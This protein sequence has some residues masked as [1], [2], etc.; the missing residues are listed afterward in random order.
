VVVGHV[1]L[2]RRGG[3]L[4]PGGTAWYTSR[5]LVAMG[6]RPR[7]LT[8]AG[9]DYQRE[10]LSG[11][12]A[13]VRPAA[14]T[15]VFENIHGPDG[16]RTQRVL[17][18]AP[19]LVPADLPAEESWHHADGLLL[20]LVLD[21]LVPRAFVEAV[22]APVTGLV[23]QGLLRRVGA[24]GAVSQPRWDPGPDALRGVGVAFL[25]EDDL[26]GQGPLHE[27]LAAQVP[28]VVLTH[29]ARGCELWASGR[30][31]EVGVFPVSEVD[32]TGA[33]DAFAA[34]FLLALTRGADPVE[35]A[36]LGAA[37]GSIAVEGIGGEALGR[38]GEAFERA[39]HVPVRSPLR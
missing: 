19:P 22:R 34:A 8:V 21:E 12:P 24:G 1:T 5:S 28:T 32:P 25:G 18:V 36:R 27:R 30:R 9:P 39:R 6:A 15:T 37:A 14:A 7:V 11:F 13:A 29:G 31:A 26:V 23:V 33:G 38:M 35:A 4:V 20:A 16:R 10:A 17:A 2:D 3:V